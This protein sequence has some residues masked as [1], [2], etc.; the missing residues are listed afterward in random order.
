MFYLTFLSNHSN[1]ILLKQLVD[2]YLI[3]FNELLKLF[4]FKFYTTPTQSLV[5]LTLKLR[6]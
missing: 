3:A 6:V 2:Y 5:R 4:I 1:E